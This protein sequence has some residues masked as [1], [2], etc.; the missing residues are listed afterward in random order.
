MYR[1]FFTL[2]LFT[3]FSFAQEK[4]TEN[5]IIVTLDGLRW[6]EL[7]QGADSTILFN[8]EFTK[9]QS[10]V[11]KFWNSNSEV[12][13][14]EL[15]PFFWNTIGTKGQLYGNRNYNNEVNCANLKWF[16]YP[17]YSELLVGFVEP[18][19]KSNDNIENPNSTVLEF[20]EK[21]PGFEDKVAVFST[22]ETISYI[23]RQKTSGIPANAGNVPLE[24]NLS[25]RAQ[26]VNELQSLLQNPHGARYDAFT[27]YQA[28]EYLK[29]EKPHVLFISFDETDEHGHGGR[30]D[31]YLKSA[32]K[33]DEMLRRLW[34]WVQNDPQYKNKTTLLISTDHGRGRGGK[35]IW[36]DHGLLQFGSGQIWMAAIGPDTPASGEMK[37]SMHLLQKQFAKTAAAFLGFEYS[38]VKPVGDVIETMFKKDEKIKDND[39]TTASFKL[40]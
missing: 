3:H 21:Q 2:I 28:F 1:I 15:M 37:T 29:Q 14:K 35:Q 27:F 5:I 30:Y 11:T 10:V 25:E 33:T 7:F 4:Q 13:R 22:W 6:Q 36:K 40:E 19:V 26:L 12:R 31:A 39:V 23:T 24:G 9:D 38:N 20:I 18:K 16:S 8:K 17:G 34:T 32:N